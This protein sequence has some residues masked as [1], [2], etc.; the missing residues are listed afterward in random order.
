MKSVLKISDAASIA[1]HA[2]LILSQNQDSLI[3]VK[4]IAE[5]L[6]VS[7]NHLS[8]VMQRLTKTGFVESIKGNKGGFRLII[9]P[10]KIKLLDIYEAIDGKL[11][12]KN[13]LLKKRICDGKGCVLG[14]LAVSLNKQVKEYFKKTSFGDFIK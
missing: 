10:E 9:S 13:C 5:K 8:K 14:N 6:E 3:S 12:P 4:Y 1:M 7:S 11:E 2:I